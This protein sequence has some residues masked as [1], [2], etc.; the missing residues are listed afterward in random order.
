M[1]A[2]VDF[3]WD[4]NF[5]GANENSRWCLTNR[6][7]E[8]GCFSKPVLTHGDTTAGDFVTRHNVGW[9]FDHPIAQNLRKFFSN[10]SVDDYIA[11]QRA[12][13][14][15]PRSLFVETDDIERLC[16]TI[17]GQNPS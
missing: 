4:I 6:S 7:Y 14:A 16:G 11:K 5:Y 1:Y 2:S 17:D 15:A 3:I 12:V 10:L 13:E 8:A 9:V